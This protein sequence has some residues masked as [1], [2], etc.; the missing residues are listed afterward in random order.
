M[1]PWLFLQFQL[2]QERGQ[3]LQNWKKKLLKFLFNDFS[4]VVYPWM[5]RG[6][7]KKKKTVS[8]ENIESLKIKVSHISFQHY[9]TLY[10]TTLHKP[11]RNCTQTLHLYSPLQLPSPFPLQVWLMLRRKRETVRLILLSIIS[12]PDPPKFFFSA[13]PLSRLAALIKA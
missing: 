5:E 3:V 4:L 2:T 9:R 8:S 6:K 7:R 13:D 10:N 11:V 1:I 12:S